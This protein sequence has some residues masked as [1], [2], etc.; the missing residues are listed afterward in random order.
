MCR[1]EEG[2][3]AWWQARCYAQLT[4]MLRGSE[5]FRNHCNDH[6]DWHGRRRPRYRQVWW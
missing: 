2:A 5:S 6:A 3:V 4:V 1:D